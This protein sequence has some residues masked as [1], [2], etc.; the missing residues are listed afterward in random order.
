MLRSALIATLSGMVFAILP[1]LQAGAIPG[2]FA[3]ESPVA[4]DAAPISRKK[5][6]AVLRPLCSFYVSPDGRV[7]AAA[8]ATG[9]SSAAAATAAAGGTATTV[10]ATSKRSS[11]AG[12]GGIAGFA[13]TLAARS[14]PNGSGA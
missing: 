8:S 1:A 7:S 3:P 11:A 9:S 6:D 5:A 4:R 14:K 10:A 12:G 13:S 2:G